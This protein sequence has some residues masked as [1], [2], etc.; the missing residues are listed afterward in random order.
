MS[1]AQISF[2]AHISPCYN[3][4]MI[5][6]TS[7]KINVQGQNHFLARDVLTWPVI[8]PFLRWRYSRRIMQAVLLIL[9]NLV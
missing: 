3:S 8:G 1:A 5:P 7:V 4:A 2:A 6:Q 9:A